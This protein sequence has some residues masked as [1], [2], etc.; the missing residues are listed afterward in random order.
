MRGSGGE[1]VWPPRSLSG[2][3]RARSLVTTT[4]VKTLGIFFNA[5]A[6]SEEDRDSDPSSAEKEW[7]MKSVNHSGSGTY[8]RAEDVVSHAQSAY[9]Q[10]SQRG[11]G[12]ATCC[13]TVTRVGSKRAPFSSGSVTASCASKYAHAPCWKG[14]GALLEPLYE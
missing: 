5:P 6:I 13:D 3:T 1:V 12:D 9:C 14:T 4:P 7:S 11:S 2:P 8:C 10:R